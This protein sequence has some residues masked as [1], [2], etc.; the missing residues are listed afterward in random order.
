MENRKTHNGTDGI[1]ARRRAA[2]TERRTERKLKAGALFGGIGG[3]CLAFEATGF[4]TAW[5]NDV[6][7]YACAVYRCNFPN[8]RLI[9]KDIRNL[10]VA[11]DK[12]E[13]VDVLHAGFPCQSFSQAGSRAGFD[14]ERGQLFFELIRLINEFGINKPAAVVLENAPYLKWG[15]GG[16]WFLEVTRQLQ[17]AGYWFRESS[18]QE[19]LDRT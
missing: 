5:V 15:A 16:T 10:S 9:E 12:L 19:L 18:A 4:E 11:K 8:N 1:G 6:D 3:F 14:D 7:P 13:P 2:K 17:R